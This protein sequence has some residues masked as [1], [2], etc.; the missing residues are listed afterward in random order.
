MSLAAR[1]P[2]GVTT[3]PNEGEAAS[4]PWRRATLAAMSGTWTTAARRT[5][6]AICL[7]P[8]HAHPWAGV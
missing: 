3:M 1:T 8:G 4:T 5:P 7:S 6:G 2:A